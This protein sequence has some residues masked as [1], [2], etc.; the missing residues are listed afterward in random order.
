M[1]ELAACKN[2][3][4]PWPAVSMQRSENVLDI[5][6]LCILRRS[7]EQL[8]S[9]QA[10]IYITDCQIPTLRFNN[11]NARSNALRI[12]GLL[13]A[14]CTQQSRLLSRTLKRPLLDI[15][16]RVG[17]LGRS[18]SSSSSSLFSLPKGV[19]RNESRVPL[20]L[21]AIVVEFGPG[22]AASP[23][24]SE[25]AG[26][27][28]RPGATREHNIVSSVRSLRFSPVIRWMETLTTKT[29]LQPLRGKRGCRQNPTQ[30]LRPH[31]QSH[32]H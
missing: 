26:D 24:T 10:C 13:A 31:I 8:L 11:L 12:D 9:L 6:V 15:V 23:Q 3:T 21:L 28:E 27:G 7:C 25:P 18:S 2:R 30:R 22:G 4:P 5:F 19:Q 17:R 32:R 29:K 1:W 16:T 20:G 14:I